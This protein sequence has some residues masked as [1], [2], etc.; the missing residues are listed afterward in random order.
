MI[1]GYQT[2]DEQQLVTACAAGDRIAQRTLYDRYVDYM[3]LTCLR[4]IPEQED[5]RETMLDGFLNVY[6]HIG[7]FEYRGAGSL[8]AWMKTIMVNRCLMFLRKKNNVLAQADEFDYSTEPQ[9]DTD[10]LSRLTMKELMQQIHQLPDGYR[11]VFNLFVF[12]DMPHKQIATLLGISENTSKSQ[13]YKAKT[14][15]QKTI[16]A[17]TKKN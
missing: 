7:S 9:V 14:L 4:Y 5:A 11:T 3:M 15:L 8:K 13:L 1:S 12:E 6:K 2:I 17:T 16:L 10:A